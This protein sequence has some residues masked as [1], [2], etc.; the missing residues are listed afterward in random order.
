MGL[1][2][3]DQEQETLNKIGVRVKKC[4]LLSNLQ[5]LVEKRERESILQVLIKDSLLW[6]LQRSVLI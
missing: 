2:K 3:D 5:E 6:I 1:A 4:K